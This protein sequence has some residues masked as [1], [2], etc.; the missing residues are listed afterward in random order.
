VVLFS[1]LFIATNAHLRWKIESVD[2]AATL[3][4]I[5]HMDKYIINT[6]IIV[7]T[8]VTFVLEYD[9]TMLHVSCLIY[10]NLSMICI[11]FKSITHRIYSFENYR[12]KIDNV[13]NKNKK[14]KNKQTI[15]SI[16]RKCE[17]VST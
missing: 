1:A 13:K 8:N 11:T 6:I 3:S 7:A 12:V 10:R 15:Y 2:V 4:N 14:H 17:R 9:V 5:L 16:P